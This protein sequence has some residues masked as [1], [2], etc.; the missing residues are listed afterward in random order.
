MAGDITPAVLQA[1]EALRTVQLDAAV[2]FPAR[3]DTV[4]CA[5]STVQW[6]H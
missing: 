3:V 6:A 4:I 2:G 5:R 1:A